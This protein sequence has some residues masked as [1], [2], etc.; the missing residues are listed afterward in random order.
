MTDLIAIASAILSD[1]SRTV[2]TSAQNVANIATPGYKRRSDFSEMLQAS[3]GDA[4]LTINRQ[5]S[6]DFSAGK[7]VD[8]GNPYDLA[9]SGDGF[10]AVRTA[11]GATVYT[12]DGQFTRD[13][14][15]HL[16]D[17][18]G[19]T[20]QADGRDLVLTGSKVEIQPDGVVLEDGSPTARL[21]L[22]KFTDRTT[23]TPADSAFSAPADAMETADAAQVRQGA[24][25]MSN[26]STA[27]E[28]VS[29]MG[30]LRRAET[31]QRL[32]TVYDDLM[33][34]VITSFG[35]AG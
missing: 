34:R 27:A 23:A 7:V 5:P 10:L 1:A 14:D 2:E 4:E 25:E 8:T 32:T 28:M 22:M 15:G 18:R 3:P 29:M 16:V 31:G 12:R 24:L 9:L 30:A 13:S 21:D 20:L 11:A 35:Q 33:G 17:A 6:V 19:G 26:T